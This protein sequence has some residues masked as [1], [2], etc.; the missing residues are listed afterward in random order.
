MNGH[1]EE[2]IIHITH[3]IDYF[4]SAELN[5]PS[6]LLQEKHQQANDYHAYDHTSE[7]IKPTYINKHFM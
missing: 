3:K 7:C 5:K 1:Q 2:N 4:S 6:T